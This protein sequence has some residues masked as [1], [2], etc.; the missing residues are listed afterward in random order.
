MCETTQRWLQQRKYMKRGTTS[1]I[2]DFKPLCSPAIT[3]QPFIPANL[4]HFKST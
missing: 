4:A 1:P 3:V 2:R